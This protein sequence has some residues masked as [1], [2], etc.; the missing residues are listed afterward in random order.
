MKV[1]LPLMKNVLIPLAKSVL[2]LL[3]LTAAASATGEVIKLNI[4]GSGIISNKETKDI[5]K[6]VKYGVCLSQGFRLR[7]GKTRNYLIQELN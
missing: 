6:I 3:K 7:N 5:V 2:T 1:G 4:Q